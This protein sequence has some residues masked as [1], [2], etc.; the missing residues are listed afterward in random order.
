MIRLNEEGLIWTST[1]WYV[2]IEHQHSVVDIALHVPLAVRVKAKE[3]D[4]PTCSGAGTPTSLRICE[5]I[6]TELTSAY[7][8]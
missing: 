4:V 1:M 5:T 6:S 7:G 8:Y 2:H 3:R